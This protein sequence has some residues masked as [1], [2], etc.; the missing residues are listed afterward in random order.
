MFAEI[1]PLV[2]TFNEAANIRRTLARLTWARDIV[3]VDSGS[4][5]ET[6]EIVKEFPQVRVF[7]R[8]FTT[9]VEQWNYGLQETGIATE[10]VLA[11]DADYVLSD[12]LLSE[13]EAL[14]PDSTAAG[15]RA[16]FKYCVNG[17]ALRGCAYPPVVVLFRRAGAKYLQDGHTQRVEI[18][19]RLMSLAAPIYHDDRKSLIHWRSAQIRYMRLEAEKLRTTP[20]SQLGAADRVRRLIVVAPAVIFLYCLLLRGGLLDG[21]A[22]LFYAVQRTVAEAILSFYLVKSYF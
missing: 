11:L 20:F 8:R 21:K 5:D 17:K 9:H 16:A 22:G 1:T 6:L 10:W 12:A 4:T 2:L 14:T 7:E 18:S 3:V 15:Y 19:G 13:F